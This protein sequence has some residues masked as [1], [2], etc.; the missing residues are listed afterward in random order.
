L[1]RGCACGKPGRENVR[2]PYQQSI[3]HIRDAFRVGMTLLLDCGRRELY[4]CACG[5]HVYLPT[6]DQASKAG[7]LANVAGP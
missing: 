3:G 5:D 7:H 2:V 4:C 1:L 6:F